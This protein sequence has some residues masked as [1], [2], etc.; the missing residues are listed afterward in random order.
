LKVRA[1]VRGGERASSNR[2]GIRGLVQVKTASI[3]AYRGWTTAL[4][5]RVLAK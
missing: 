5:G 3:Q 4:Y 1:Y 2:L